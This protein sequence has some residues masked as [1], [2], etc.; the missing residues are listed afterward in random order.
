MIICTL[1]FGCSSHSHQVITIL[2][3]TEPEVCNDPAS[4]ELAV[5]T[6]WCNTQFTSVFLFFSHLARENYLSIFQFYY[7]KSSEVRLCKAFL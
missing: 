3:G 4:L 5:E 1:Y 7:S 6:Y 2:K